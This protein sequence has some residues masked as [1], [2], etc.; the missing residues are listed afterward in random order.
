MSSRADVQTLK[1][2]G[3]WE[4]VQECCWRKLGE[5]Y[6][7]VCDYHEGWVDAWE[8]EKAN[9][10]T[11]EELKAMRG[12]MSA[13]EDEY[14]PWDKIHSDSALRRIEAILKARKEKETP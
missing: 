1:E 7:Y 12:E 11:D 14:G 9:D 5:N 2:S 10:F 3:V 13:Y 4:R 6:G 8:A